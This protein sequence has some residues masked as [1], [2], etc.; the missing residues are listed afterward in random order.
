M[1]FPLKRQ[2]F[3]FKT[4]YFGLK[5]IK[6]LNFSLQALGERSLTPTLILCFT[7]IHQDPRLLSL[8]DINV[9]QSLLV[10]NMTSY[11]RWKGGQMIAREAGSDLELVLLVPFLG[12]HMRIDSSLHIAS[13]D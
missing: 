12:L 5:Q 2:R 1:F 6:V 3:S 7:L 4:N 8:S 13:M 10:S 9:H 11:Y